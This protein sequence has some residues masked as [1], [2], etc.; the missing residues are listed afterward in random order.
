MRLLLDYLCTHKHFNSV[1]V[2][3]YL[4]TLVACQCGVILKR[5]PYITN[6]HSTFSV[7]LRGPMVDIRNCPI[8]IRNVFVY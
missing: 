6:E 4:L 7:Q 8:K 3:V 5:L 1:D 2:L